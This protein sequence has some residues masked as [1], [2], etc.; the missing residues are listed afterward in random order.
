MWLIVGLG[1]PGLRYRYTRHNI[2]FRV[3]DRLSKELSIPVAKKGL[4]AKWGNG[5]WEDRDVVLAKP[6]TFMN[7]S[8]DAVVRLATFFGAE[9]GY[10]IVI[11]DDL[12]LH[13]GEI[14]IREKGGDG[15]HRGVRSIIDGL[16]RGEFIRVRMGIS[17]PDMQG[18][19]Q[20]FVLGAFSPQEKKVLKDHL[21]KG[22]E[23]VK[24]IIV[25]G[26]SVAMNRFNRRV[27]LKASELKGG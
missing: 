22:K 11:H 2:G 15:G 10:L 21:D 7:L 13:L 27:R 19:E 1:N 17:R 25:E 12:D 6:Q 26:T 8:G 24:T 16:G 18:D 4:M 9:R 5:Y 3:I 14:R 20:D 23:A